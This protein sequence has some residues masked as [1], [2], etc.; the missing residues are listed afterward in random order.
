[1]GIKFRAWNKIK[2][3]Y[4]Y[5]G[6]SDM[7]N[8][9][10]GLFVLE[11]FDNFIIEQFT[12]FVDKNGVD[13]YENDIIFFDDGEG[14]RAKRKQ[15]EFYLGAFVIYYG[16]DHINLSAYIDYEIEVVGNV[17]IKTDTDG[18]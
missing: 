7:F 14:R 5:F 13:V 18:K 16:I 10:Y 17:N 12:G 8:D 3:E 9:R 1:M 15:V 11:H 4:T 2:C 6:L